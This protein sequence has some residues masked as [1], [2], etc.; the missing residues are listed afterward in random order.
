VGWVLMWQL[1]LL[2]HKQPLLQQHSLGWWWKSPLLPLLLLP[3]IR[4]VM[5]LVWQGMDAGMFQS[6]QRQQQ[7]QR[8]ATS[9]GVP[10]QQQQQQGV[11]FVQYL[12]TFLLLSVM[13][14]AHS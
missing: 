8:Q 10:E 5:I 13:M 9:V 12:M 1:P 11:G 7:Q 14:K 3:L 4:M 2:P 6:N